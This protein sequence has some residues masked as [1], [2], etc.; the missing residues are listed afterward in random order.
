MYQQYWSIFSFFFFFTFYLFLSFIHVYCNL[1]FI[2]VRSHLYNNLTW[3][4][5]LFIVGQLFIKTISVNT[6]LKNCSDF[7]FVVLSSEGETQYDWKNWLNFLEKLWVFTA[8][9]FH[10]SKTLQIVLK[11]KINTTYV[12][13][14]H[15][16]TSKWDATAKKKKLVWTSN[17]N[18]Y[19]PISIYR[20][21]NSL[22]AAKCSTML[23]R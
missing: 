16:Y 21:T 12:T 18:N 1:L 13:V 19:R 22:W 7:M 15:N 20:S 11:N 17:L 4:P 8:R 9:S 2:L 10:W 3:P 5:E 14:S 6:C 23:S